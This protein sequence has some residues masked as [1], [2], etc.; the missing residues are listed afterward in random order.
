MATPLG[1]AAS[2]TVNVAPQAAAAAA[3]TSFSL[4]NPSVI[5][6]AQLSF[7]Q[8]Y[9]VGKV[10][11]QAS[12]APSYVASHPSSPFR[13]AVHVV[14]HQE[15]PLP[16]RI[17][18]SNCHELAPLQ[19]GFGTVY[20]GVRIRDG[21]LVAIKHVA[22]SNVTEWGEVSRRTGTVKLKWSKKETP[23][24]VW[25]AWQMAAEISTIFPIFS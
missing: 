8:C 12:L 18:E 5:A 16:P 9:R 6:Q 20:A 17:S 23:M 21:A 3:Q 13:D 24:N 14:P 2:F 15:R 4:P 11:G 25:I 19:G 1:S 7:E 10:L 22:K